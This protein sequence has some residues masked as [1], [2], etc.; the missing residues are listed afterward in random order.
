MESVKHMKIKTGMTVG[1][2]VDE[3]GECGILGAGRI[4]RATQLL[5]EMFKDPDYTVF[6]ALAG[7]M[8]PGGLRNI[9]G[10]LI[11]Q[12]HVNVIVAS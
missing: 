1:Q 6:L 3:M 5:A 9:I 8:I 12:K 10:E 7:P 2:L 11:D 4:A